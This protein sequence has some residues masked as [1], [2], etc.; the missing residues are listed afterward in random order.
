MANDSDLAPSHRRQFL[1]GLTAA[2]GTT[3][4]TP[5]TRGDEPPKDGHEPKME[6]SEKAEVDAR[7]ALVLARFGDKL[8][9]KDR[10][11]VRSQV[12]RQV[13]RDRTLRQV[14][15]ENGGGAFPPFTPYPAGGGG[16]DAAW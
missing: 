2:V 8:E 4:F 11:K 6:P 5:V 14:K 16:K 12:E 9:P 7:M 13:K 3:A 15:L 10:D 1:A